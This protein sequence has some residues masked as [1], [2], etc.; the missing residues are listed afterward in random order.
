MLA[1]GDL[2]SYEMNTKAEHLEERKGLFLYWRWKNR[3]THSFVFA[4]DIVAWK[5][6]DQSVMYLSEISLFSDGKADLSCLF[7]AMCPFIEII[8]L[9]LKT[10]LYSLGFH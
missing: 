1:T 10:R 5:R 4:D 9:S 7:I 6:A 3:L 8:V 2:I